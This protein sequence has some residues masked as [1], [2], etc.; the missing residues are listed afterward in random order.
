MKTWTVSAL[1]LALNA[2]PRSASAQCLE[3]ADGFHLPGGSGI[4]GNGLAMVQFDDGN[5]P[6]LFVA[7]Q[8]THAGYFVANS[9]ARWSGTGWSYLG[10]G[11]QYGPVNALCVFDDGSGPA[12]FAGGYFQ[13]ANPVLANYIAKWDAAAYSWRTLGAGM[14]DYVT[15]LAV[16]D[17]GTGVALYAAG[18]FLYADNNWVNQLAKWD[19]IGFAAAGQGL[20]G[21]PANVL[22]V[23]DDGAGAKL[24]AG[25]TTL[26][27]PSGNTTLA[28]FDGA[29]WTAVSGAPDGT[30]YSLFVYDDGGGPQLHVGGSFTRAGGQSAG[31]IAR[32]NGT[33]WST[34]SSGV[35]GTGAAVR[36]MTAHDDGN[37]TH[38]YVGGRFTTAGAVNARNIARWSG[39]Q[40][41]ALGEGVD[42]NSPGYTPMVYALASFTLGDPQR[43][44]LYVG[45]S[46]NLAGNDNSVGFALWHMLTAPWC[47]GPQPGTTFCTGDGLDPLLTTPCPCQNNG[48][49][50]QGCGNSY[51]HAGGR[52]L[53][54]GS[55]SLD[56]LTGTDSLKLRG[57]DMP[58]VPAGLGC[59]FLQ[60]DA[61]ESAGVPFGDGILCIS[62]HLIRLGPAGMP[63]GIAEYPG[64]GQLSVSQRGGVTPGGGA[65]R[66]YQTFYRNSNSIYCT[67]STFNV[68]NAVQITW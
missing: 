34:F 36:A 65:V 63:V 38:L 9:I 37:G 45:G 46:L 41:S 3:W 57:S 43:H 21:T 53:A 35:S 52:L 4:G 59:I 15:A 50:G 58:N 64:A 25:G 17:D 30:V 20:S 47:S 23:Y 26:V 32:W 29:T 12:V 62:G 56:P 1:L 67:P 10:N 13:Y 18:H 48:A 33:A 61:M 22:C 5:G 27:L 28:S 8:F 60:A 49:Q 68:T 44:E 14:S 51:H 19:G 11:V 31:N 40:W 66:S 6:G 42:Q 54:Y 16:Y 39:S 2:A 7:G 24:Y 55:T